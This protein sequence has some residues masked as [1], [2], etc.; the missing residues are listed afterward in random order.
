MSKD[1]GPQASRAYELLR[2]RI[3]SGKPA[4]G[5][6]LP[7]QPTLAR[8]CGVSLMTLR[9]ALARL[10]REELVVCEHGR[11]TFVRGEISQTQLERAL[12][13]SEERFYITFEQAAVG[14]AHNALDG[15]WLLANQS[16]C[17][18][19]GYS[20][21]EL[22]Q[23]H[24]QELTH[25]DD[26]APDLLMF[27]KLVAGEIPSYH[28]EKRHIRK[29]G[30]VVWGHVTVSLV[31]D[32]DGD[33]KYTIGVVKDI[34]ER[35]RADERILFQARLLEA[36]SRQ[37]AAIAHI[38]H[39]GLEGADLAELMNEA[40]ELITQTLDVQYSTILEWVPSEEAL[41]ARAGSGWT[42][43]H[44]GQTI[45]AGKESQVGFTL[46]SGEPVV[47]TD[48]RAETRFEAHAGLMGHGVVSSMT[49]IIARQDRPLGV[50]GVYTTQPRIFSED[51]V[52]F[53]QVTANVLAAAID[54]RRIEEALAHQALHDGLT[55]LPNRSLL[56]D[57]LEHAIRG[58]RRVRGPLA[59]LL[60]DLDRF[61]EVNDTLGHHVGDVLLAEVAKRFSETLRESDTVARLGG[62][63]FAILL[64]GADEE[65]AE[66]AAGR[67]LTG[68]A[69]PFALGDQSFYLTASIGIAIY[70]GHGND[71]ATL[72]RCADVAMYR[73]KHHGTGFA[74]YEAD[75]D[76]H[77]SQRLSLTAD[78]GRAIE[79]GQLVLHYQP[80]VS[81]RT[82]EARQAEALVRWIHPQH[83][84][85]SPDQFIGLA[86]HTG[87]IKPLTHWVLGEALRQASA[88]QD[89][90]FDLCVA[91]NLSAWN[92]RDPELVATI[93]GLLETCG[94][95]SSNLQLE[96]TESALMVDPARA[97]ATLTALHEMGI[98]VSIDDFGTGYSSLAYLRDL[99]VDEIKIDRSF[100]LD[101]MA[102][103]EESFV[104]IR[105][106]IDL[107]HNL[108]L[109]VVAEGVETQYNLDVLEAMGCDYAQ[110]YRLSRPIRAADYSHWLDAWKPSQM[111]DLRPTG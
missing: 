67:L 106:V 10:E 101:M 103:V 23:R 64:N 98:K 108:G 42:G 15:R 39:R 16:L 53:L 17:D 44:A 41:V 5:T 90:G 82:G 92:L 68:L 54:R 107:G 1:L 49:V 35:K 25:P 4:C 18:F 87:F 58:I 47:V 34:S 94:T 105:S 37:Q 51:D 36:R 99:P 3:I 33:P 89:A 26:L 43:P 110:G 74:T 55:G 22:H 30:S 28:I 13:E 65:A 38:T 75:N 61:K 91:V 63:E 97:M 79:L 77:S 85:I 6:R 29:D 21:E 76:P 45:R 80:K 62:D 20:A 69:Q 48:L 50:L 70:P 56:L 14:I 46:L 88:W 52:N 7:N 111:L 96:I 59:L 71:P 2:R 86:E 40:V 66:R 95:K 72:L 27:G 19:Y 104:I 12:L 100:V 81:L 31:R 83:G 102:G 24:F 73:A 11:G 57:R 60:L 93:A 32:A 84:L 109:E 78:L 9:Q 8:E